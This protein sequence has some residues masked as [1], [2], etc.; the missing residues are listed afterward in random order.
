MEADALLSHLTPASVVAPA[1]R[2]TR[3]NGAR[4]R[5]WREGNGRPVLFVHGLGASVELWLPNVLGLKDRLAV[6]AVDLPGFGRSE[7][8]TMP[9]S[10]PNGARFL[11]DFVDVLG[12]ERVSLVGNSMGGVLCLQFALDYPERLDRLVLIASAG[13]G[14]ELSGS[15]CT[16]GL[17]GVPWLL[18]KRSR[19]EWVEPGLRSCLADPWC[20]S[21][22]YVQMCIA[23]CGHRQAMA[24]FVEAVR[25]GVTLRGQHPRI[26]L[27]D[28]LHAVR[29]PTL[30]IWGQQDAVIPVHHAYNA[31]ERL[32]AGSLVVLEN[33]GHCPQ[34]EQ[35]KRVNSL[36]EQFLTPL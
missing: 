29:A 15:L 23:A 24:S 4:V 25:V 14:R 33:C 28:R 19:P 6:I 36:L 21:S 3:V 27:R 7:R 5:Y 1:D 22:E 35:P 2:Y 9:Y 20:V 11:R 12:F 18:L 26:V 17:P 34:I 31:C 13:L 8:G 32:P 16:L 10:L 30:L